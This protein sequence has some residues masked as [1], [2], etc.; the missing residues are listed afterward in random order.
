MILDFNNLVT[1]YKCDITGVIHIGG[2]HGQ[3]YELYKQLNVPVL[4][5]EPVASSFNILYNKVKHDPNI[6]VYQCALG[7]E[8][9]YVYMNI[10]TANNGQ[11]SSILKP[12]KHL[13][14]YPHI[15]FNSTERVSM[16]RLDDLDINLSIYN[17]INVDV[18][19]Y[20]L[21]VFKGASNTLKNINYI[22]SEVN[23]DELYEGCAYVD[24]IDNHLSQ[25]SFKRVETIWSKNNW[26]DA[27]YI[28]Q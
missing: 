22:I 5:F 28:K 15:V 10:E 27:L 7:N 4:F 25:F 13:T 23:N 16:F 21:E 6:T 24:D 2:H 12:K 19:G 17:F 8:N 3:E 18:Q 26:V 9:A 11:S 14:H 1:N 20:E